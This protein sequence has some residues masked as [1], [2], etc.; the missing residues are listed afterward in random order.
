MVQCEEAEKQDHHGGT[1]RPNPAKRKFAREGSSP[2]ASW[3]GRSLRCTGGNFISGT[4][5]FIEVATGYKLTLKLSNGSCLAVPPLVR[6]GRSGRRHHDR[7]KRSIVQD[8]LPEDVD[9]NEENL[10]A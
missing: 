10:F 8:R 5:L 3:L 4:D 9:D 6:E 7:G 1:M 2:L